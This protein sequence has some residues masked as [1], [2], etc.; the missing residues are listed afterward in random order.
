MAIKRNSKAHLAFAQVSSAG[1]LQGQDLLQMINAG[2]NPLQEI[3]RTTGKSMASLKEQMSQGGITAKMVEQAFK[4]ATAEGGMF[5]GMMEKQS[6]TLAGKWST[7][8]GKFQ[9]K[10]TELGEKS[11]PFLG[12]IVDFG[13]RLADGMQPII[14]AWANVRAAGTALWCPAQL[15]HLHRPHQRPNRRCQRP[16]MCS[17]AS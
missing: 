4:S 7:L 9:S 3:S 8:V 17:Q 2:F 14:D 1:K 5:N 6:Q 13:I 12:R 11:T 16:E 15:Y 10:I